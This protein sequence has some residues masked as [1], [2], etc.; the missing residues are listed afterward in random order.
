MGD[1]FC[2]PHYK[3]TRAD[4]LEYLHKMVRMSLFYAYWHTSITPNSSISDSI[5]NQTLL[6]C[7]TEFNE[8]YLSDTSGASTSS[9]WKNLLIKIHNVHQ[10]SNT[11]QEFEDAAFDIIKPHL[12]SKAEKDLGAFAWFAGEDYHSRS[13]VF[14]NENSTGEYLPIHL[15]NTTY[16]ISFLDNPVKFKSNLLSAIEFAEKKG[17]RGISVTTWLNSKQRYL[18][19]F[20]KSYKD[21]EIVINMPQ[22][23]NLGFWGQFL[24][25]KYTFNDWSGDYFRKNLKPKYPV[26]VCKV[27]LQ[28]LKN[29]INNMA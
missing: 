13:I 25:G 1:N 11:S 26:S 27:A 6:F 12:E 9:G 23:N 17:F 18:D 29:H 15:E 5:N 24:T 3:K 7:Q 16:P 28:D 21:S 19:F 10:L 4:H 20:P 14:F 2:K 22:N 8:S